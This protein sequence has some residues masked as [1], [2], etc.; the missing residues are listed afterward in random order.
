VEC[1][2]RQT[3]ASRREAEARIDELFGRSKQLV[4]D[5]YDTVTGRRH[6][7]VPFPQVIQVPH[8]VEKDRF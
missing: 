5:H 4:L 3:Y 2:I 7:L 6:S 1:A 8:I